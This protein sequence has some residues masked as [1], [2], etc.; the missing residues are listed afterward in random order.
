M[1]FVIIELNGRYQESGHPSGGVPRSSAAS[2]RVFRFDRFYELVDRIAKRKSPERVLVIRRENFSLPAFGAL[3]EVAAALKRLAAAGKELYYYA[4]EYEVTD[5]V[6]ASACTHR[7]LHPLGTVSFTGISLRGLFF[8]NLIDKHGIGVT[9][10]RR[11]RYKS[12]ADPF[13][14]DRYDEHSRA[15]YE[16]LVEGAVARMREMVGGVIPG[17][18]LEEM[19][20]GR[21]LS[22]PEA[23]QSSFAHDLCP[24]ET[25]VT[26]WKEGKGKKIREWKAGKLRGAYGS[27]PRVAVLF[28]EGAITEGDTHRSPL[29]G[30]TLGDRA[31]IR[32]IRALRK[33]RRV[34]AVV[35][36]VNSGGGSA[37]ASESILRELEALGEK[38]PL[39]VS[40]GPLA[41]SG[42]YW[43][44]TTGRRLFALPTTITGSVGVITLFFDLSRFLSEKGI[45]TDCVKRGDSADLGSALRPL[46]ESERK[47][48][49]TVVEHLYQ[50]FLER[51]ATF[52]GMTP[53]QADRLG[54]GRLWLGS[55]A[56]QE[57]LVD[58]TGGLRDAIE[59]ARSLVGAKTV[60]LLFRPRVKPS[61]ATRF[62]RDARGAGTNAPGGTTNAALSALAGEL[63]AL[64]GRPLFADEFLPF[65]QADYHDHGVPT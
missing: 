56:R 11:G 19:I 22:A 53:E 47:Q 34:K 43:I 1:R 33:S 5:C 46:S 64:Q 7:I 3:E 30:N 9:V 10:I 2:R 14:T 20:G 49:D 25:F 50:L 40:M 60:R 38:K 59:Y 31:L 27:G 32:S 58:E 51:V 52:R 21:I 41:G 42:G 23:L 13:R 6:L 57:G 18:L 61:L 54:E 26:Q 44:S 15:Q 16:A 8:R 48:I 24:L 36:R 12:A 35:F 65:L 62:L 28:F 39:V 4:S 45:T 17:E 29:L 55:A 63:L 37:I